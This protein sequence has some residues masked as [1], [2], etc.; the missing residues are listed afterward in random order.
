MWY[1]CQH[2]ILA[3]HRDL[4]RSWPTLSKFPPRTKF[5]L[6][7]GD[8]VTAHLSR[9]QFI[10]W[11]HRG[12]IFMCDCRSLNP[13]FEGGL[14]HDCHEVM[15]CLLAYVENATKEVNKHRKRMKLLPGTINLNPPGEWTV[16]C[17]GDGWCGISGVLSTKQGCHSNRKI[18]AFIFSRQKIYF[19]YREIF[20]VL[21]IKE[22][23][24]FRSCTRYIVM[25][26]NFALVYFRRG[27]GT[28][29]G[30]EE[31]GDGGQEES[32][33]STGTEVLTSLRARLHRAS[34]SMLR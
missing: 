20:E 1:L 34:E 18:R 28:V 23:F 26:L 30:D 9:M 32:K 24:S 22:Q 3:S 25:S 17:H 7:S 15:R 4:G 6:S 19:E 14:Q 10:V 2:L 21:T 11:S 8:E 16:R 13:M 33:N 5:S 29:Q 31:D 27:W 12:I